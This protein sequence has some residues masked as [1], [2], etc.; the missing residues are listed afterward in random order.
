MKILETTRLS[1]FEIELSDNV[2]VHDLL[3]SPNWMKYI[4]D[5]GVHNHEDATKFISER[6]IKSYTEFGFGFYKMV[7]KETGMDI[8]I[9]GLIK[10]PELEFPDIGFAVFPEYEG[11]GFTSEAAFAT[12][13]YAK[14]RLGLEVILGV[15]SHDNFGSR[16]VLE[17]VGLSL[18]GNTKISTTDEDLLLF[19]NQ[20]NKDGETK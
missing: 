14:N 10:R 1:L 19:S 18:V 2:F 9:C 13:D 16:R 11:C 3:N 20:H 8:G 15:T 4:G 6:L 17:K 5:R 12:M 7:L